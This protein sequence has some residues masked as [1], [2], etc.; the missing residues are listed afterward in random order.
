MTLHT[1]AFDSEYILE[2]A[3]LLITSPSTSL[4]IKVND[5]KCAVRVYIFLHIPFFNWLQRHL[6]WCIM[7]PTYTKRTGKVT[8]H[9]QVMQQH[10]YSCNFLEFWWCLHQTPMA[11]TIASSI[12][13]PRTANTAAIAIAAVEL[14]LSGCITFGVSTTSDSSTS[15]VAVYGP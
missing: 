7:E 13:Q 11:M 2:I 15:F 10:S 9:L 3:L 1:L 5:W 12:T 14:P 6:S 4:N 8:Y